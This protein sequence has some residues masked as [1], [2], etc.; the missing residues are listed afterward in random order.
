M[1]EK[2]GIILKLLPHSADNESVEVSDEPID[3]E[4]IPDG[5]W[6]AC[7]VAFGSFTAI[8]ATFGVSA[9][10]GTIQQYVASHQLSDYSTSSVGWIF[11]VQLFLF[12]FVGIQVGPIFDTYGL[13]PLLFPG[14]I[15]WCLAIMF[16]SE[17]HEYYQFMLS[18]GIFGGLASSTIF[19]PSV[20]VIS[21]WFLRRRSRAISF[22]A[23]GSAIGGLFMPKMVSRLIPQVGYAWAVRILGFIVLFLLLITCLLMR[24]RHRR[25]THI[26]WRESMIDISALK[27]KEFVACVIGL[28]FVEWGIFIP[29]IYIP[30]YAVSQNW[31]PD[32]YLLMY[33]NASSFVSRLLVGWLA[34]KFGT[35]NLM[36]F[37]ALGAGIV[38]FALWLPAG[39]HHNGLI[40]FV[41]VFG[42][43]SGAV[44]AMTLTVIPAL[45]QPKNAGRRYGTAYMIASF[46]VLTGSPIAGALTDHN[47]L[48]LILF[49]GCVYIAGSL[50]FAISRWWAAPNRWVY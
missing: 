6:Q 20:T 32:N 27:E 29:Q 48:G 38:C 8:V 15:C 22:A 39:P 46:A 1:G 40:A 2:S 14:C 9:A 47:Y 37:N 19:N 3:V 26:D 18:Y 43:F 45:A 31:S 17:S 44:I 21:H 33:M 23:S 12:Y 36:I 24:S 30:T 49:T 35:F 28:F 10:V 4:H 25:R 16:L 13:P 5:G 34:D 7:L 42:W 11:S 41:V 50:C